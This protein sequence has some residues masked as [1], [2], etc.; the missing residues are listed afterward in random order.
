MMT[1]VDHPRKQ[2]RRKTA[3]PSKRLLADYREAVCQIVSARE[4]VWAESLDFNR[5]IRAV[6]QDVQKMT[7]ASA[8]GVALLVGDKFVYRAGVGLPAG[9]IGSHVSVGSVPWQRLMRSG[10]I[11]TRRGGRPETE[12]STVCGSWIPQSLLAVPV[13]RGFTAAGFLELLFADRYHFEAAD[14]Q[15][16][17]L[18]AGI[19]SEILAAESRRRFQIVRE[20]ERVWFLE[21]FKIARKGLAAAQSPSQPVPSNPTRPAA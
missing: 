2:E 19:V 15:A 4:R 20:R 3:D 14:T 7:H 18:M 12:W 21:A 1:S 17:Q 8:V 5:M 9:Q 6:A 16:V 11:G 13:Y 10:V